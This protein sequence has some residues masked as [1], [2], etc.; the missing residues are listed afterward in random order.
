MPQ[1]F[2]NNAASKLATG[3]NDTDNTIVLLDGSS[4]PSPSGG[5]FFN[6][7]LAGVDSNGLENAWEIVKVTARSADTLT[8]TRAQEGT[9]A[10]VW[11]SNTIA[12]LRVT[13]AGLAGKADKQDAAIDD[14]IT[15]VN[16]NT[17]GDAAVAISA[18][19]ANYASVSFRTNQVD[20]WF[21]GKDNV[22]EGGANA[23]SNFFLGA[24]SDA[25]AWVENVFTVSRATQ[26]LDFTYRPTVGGAGLA[27]QSDLSTLSAPTIN[28]YTEGSATAS[29]TAFSPNLADDT[30][31]GYTTTGNTTITLPTVVAGKSF[32]LQIHFG[33][34]H[35]VG[36]AGGAR[37]FATGVT[38]APTSTASK[39]DVLNFVA[40]SAGTK[41]LVS[42]FGQGYAT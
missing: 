31:F 8:V 32:Q 34:A 38:Y 1:L 23:G 24:F 35:T 28:G 6:L 10:A 13:A 3:I 36:W 30:V 20:R 7:T 22:A 21:F 29:G 17:V 33:G 9:A 4:F 39:T 42:I 15:I 5:D 25:G 2:V 18:K 19:T 27:L 40:N 26:I 14:S 37:E 41:W 12:Q 11:A 16:N